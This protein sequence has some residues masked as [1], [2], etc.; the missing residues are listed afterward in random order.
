MFYYNAA[1]WSP[2]C[3]PLA[4]AF[5]ET[6]FFVILSYI[7]SAS[8]S[9]TAWICWKWWECSEAPTHLTTSSQNCQ[10]RQRSSWNWLINSSW[11][12]ET[13]RDET[14]HL[15]PIPAVAV[16]S[17]PLW[18]L[19]DHLSVHRFLSFSFFFFWQGKGLFHSHLQI[20]LTIQSSERRNQEA[21]ADA[22][23]KEGWWQYFYLQFLNGKHP[24]HFC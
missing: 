6:R 24:H 23:A 2:G 11:W 3:R 21:R 14:F 22:E 20:K 12:K 5:A 7:L 10:D 16:W 8:L 9:F 18:F 13:W 15:V 1:L 19:V 17:L 4:P